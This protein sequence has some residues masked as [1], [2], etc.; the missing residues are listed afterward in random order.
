MHGA[1]EK[2]GKKNRKVMCGSIERI[3]ASSFYNKSLLRV[4]HSNPVS[5]ET[6]V[7]TTQSRAPPPCLSPGGKMGSP[8]SAKGILSREDDHV[9]KAQ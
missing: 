1:K 7:D 5:L 4:R 3:I 8:T 9:T 6:P 2:E